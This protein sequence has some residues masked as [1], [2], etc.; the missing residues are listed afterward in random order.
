MAFGDRIQGVD[1]AVLNVAIVAALIA[2]GLGLLFV[3]T[4]WP[5]AKAALFIVGP[6]A[7]LAVLAALVRAWWPRDEV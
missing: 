4:G 2:L 3:V 7:V 1:R 6:I 5:I